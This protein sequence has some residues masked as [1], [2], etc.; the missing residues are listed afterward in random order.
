VKLRLLV[1]VVAL[2]FLAGCPLLMMATQEP[3]SV[4]HA[5]TT[6]VRVI[7]L[8]SKAVCTAYFAQAGDFNIDNWLDGEQPVAAGETLEFLVKPGNYNVVLRSCDGL[9]QLSQAIDMRVPSELIVTDKD[10][11]PELA[12]VAEGFSRV[13]PF[14]LAALPERPAYVAPAASAPSYSAPAAS[15]PGGQA[16]PA[17]PAQPQFA[18]VTL[19]NSC[20]EKVKL[21]VGRKPRGSS[22]TWTS[23]GANTIQSMSGKA[24]D[25]IW[26][27]DEGGNGVSAYTYSGGSQ[28]IQITQS[29]SGFAP[30]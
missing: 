27:V 3:T 9:S 24:G 17:A 5:G 14:N 7:N 26:I 13:G 4:R 20:R 18:S 19:K 29:C 30:H 1:A 21:F 12:A 8:S 25:T 16:A 11:E 23:I 2:G 10:S 15:S 6:P 22:G 28:R